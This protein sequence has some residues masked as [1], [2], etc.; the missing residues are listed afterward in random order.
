MHILTSRFLASLL[1]GGVQV[2]ISQLQTLR[3]SYGRG[4]ETCLNGLGILTNALLSEEMQSLG[5]T[6]LSTRLI[7][8]ALG[9]P[10]KIP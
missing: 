7:L 8:P 2:S 5:G 6:W 3:Q 4:I 10:Q 1:H 9:D